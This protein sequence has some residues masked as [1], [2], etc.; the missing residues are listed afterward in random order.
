M[1]YRGFV[2]G[3]LLLMLATN[4]WAQSY[5]IQGVEHYFRLEWEKSTARRGPVVAGY[6]YNTSGFTAERV[7]LGIDFVD[8]G[9][10][11]V[12]NTMGYVLG[13]VPNGNRAYFEVP[14]RDAVSYKVRVLSFDPV[15]R[16]Q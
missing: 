16:G 6:I 11:V 8:A 13:T 2:L 9:G 12:G 5:A 4:G 10:Q 7:R 1:G 3:V 14:V 15:G